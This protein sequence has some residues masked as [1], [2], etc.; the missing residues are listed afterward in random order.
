MAIGRPKKTFDW[1]LVKRLCNMQCTKMEIAEILQV[2]DDTLIRRIKE[3]WGEDATFAAL[4]K[5]WSAGGK[6]SMRR[7]QFRSAMKGSV[8]MQIWLGKQWLDQE[9]HPEPMENPNEPDYSPP[10]FEIDKPD[11]E[12]EADGRS[13]ERK[14]RKERQIAAEE[15]AKENE[16]K[17]KAKA[18]ERG[19]LPN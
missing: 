4:F 3:K 16:A 8:V 19:I 6:V 11:E 1:K 14:T 15:I 13:L 9:D 12:D 7:L 18:S 2:S 5:R 10:S 17:E